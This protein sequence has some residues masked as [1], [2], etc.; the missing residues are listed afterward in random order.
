MYVFI[1][2]SFV[3]GGGCLMFV[4]VVVFVLFAVEVEHN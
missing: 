2:A 1:Y 3:G 4:C